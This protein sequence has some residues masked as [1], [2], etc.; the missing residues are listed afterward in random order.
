VAW[1]PITYLHTTISP[2]A[3]LALPWP[4]RVNALA[5][6]LARRGTAGA[7]ER[8]FAEGRLGLFSL[9]E[10]VSLRAATVAAAVGGRQPPSC[11]ST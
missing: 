3:R 2:G 10:A 4:D 9:G 8:P 11:S 5:Y 7:S 1:T 6:L